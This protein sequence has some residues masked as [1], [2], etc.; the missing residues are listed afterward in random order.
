MMLR[1]RADSLPTGLQ[2][3][4]LSLILLVGCANTGQ[5]EARS[6]DRHASPP[7]K[8]SS[9]SDASENRLSPDACEYRNVFVEL[10]NPDPPTDRRA[11]PLR[12]AILNRA[13]EVLPQLGWVE[14]GDPA[15]AYWR[16][17]A[18]G[19]MGRQGNPL[20]HLGMRGE[21]RLGRHLFV[22]SMADESFPFRGGLG[23][24]YNFAEASLADASQLDAQVEIGMRWIWAL[25]SEQIAALCEVRNELID[26]GWTAVEELRQELIEEMQQVRQARARSNPR[27]DLE[28]EVEEQRPS[29]RAQ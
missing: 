15:E 13:I 22:V 29:E 20:V 24:S 27:K 14:V 21:L 23:G 17:F 28:I 7:N 4:A 9:P 3:A 1:D 2:R 16:L 25:D 12:R 5:S 18:D 6:A 11:E 26:E 8:H 10:E 19:W